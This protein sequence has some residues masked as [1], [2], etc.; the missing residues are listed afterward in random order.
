MKKIFLCVFAAFLLILLLFYR[1]NQSQITTIKFHENISIEN[2]RMVTVVHKG[3]ETEIRDTNF[4]SECL[5]TLRNSIQLEKKPSDDRWD[6]LVEIETNNNG[7]SLHLYFKLLTMEEG[8]FNYNNSGEYYSIH[9]N[10]KLKMIKKLEEKG[11][12]LFD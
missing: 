10:N 9:N 3:K 4:I 5:L 8:Y 7:E 12:L 11:V 1:Y 6:L 2:V